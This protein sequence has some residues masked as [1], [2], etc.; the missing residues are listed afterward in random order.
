MV[1]YG[2]HAL[3][4]WR[5]VLV[6]TPHCLPLPLSIEHQGVSKMTDVNRTTHRMPRGRQTI[7]KGGSLLGF[8]GPVSRRIKLWT[9]DAKS[10]PTLAALER[11]YFS[12][13]DAVDRMEERSQRNAANGRLTQDG[14]KADA[15]QFAR[16]DLLPALDRARDTISRA[17]GELAER[18]AKLSYQHGDEIDELEEAIAAAESAVEA[19]YEEVRL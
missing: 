17:K 10:D 9:A 7:R 19:A 12:A 18:R 16:N 13:L 11:A 1:S 4:S 2:D 8:H 14:L 5:R 3:N 6:G 15:T